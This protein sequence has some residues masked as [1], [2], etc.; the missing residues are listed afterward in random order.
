MYT[1]MLMNKYD[2][3]FVQMLGRTCEK[4]TIVL[5]RE[6]GGENKLSPFF[7]V[8]LQNLSCRKWW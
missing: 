8:G 1:K 3:G 7:V 2:N 5:D 6:R 4:K